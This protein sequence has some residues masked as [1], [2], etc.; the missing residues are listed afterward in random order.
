[1]AIYKVELRGRSHYVINLPNEFADKKYPDTLLV[2]YYFEGDCDTRMKNADMMLGALYDLFQVND[3]LKDGDIFQT[4]FGE[5]ICQGVHV[6]KRM[7]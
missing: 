2:Y 1:M 6:I 5:Y 7:N 3:N 4:E